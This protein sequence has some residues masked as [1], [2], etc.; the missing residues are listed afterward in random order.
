MYDIVIILIVVA[1]V[2][3][4]FVY[5]ITR[6]SNIIS[7]DQQ[8]LLQSNDDK[9]LTNWY[10]N[11]TKSNSDFE[12]DNREIA[13]RFIKRILDRD[14]DFE[15]I[16]I[17]TN[18]EEQYYKIMKKIPNDDIFIDVRSLIGKS[19]EF[20]IIKNKKL[21][22]KF[23]VEAINLN[24]LNDI[25]LAD[26]DKGAYQHIK[27]LLTVRWG[28]IADLG[29]IGALNDSGSYLYLPTDQEGDEVIVK[30]NIVATKTIRGARINLLCNNWEFETLLKRLK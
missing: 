6:Y 18:L 24:E 23:E 7:D 22:D 9:I 8:L 20:L 17:G 26:Y 13:A 21:R 1:L 3:I 15:H 30:D 5:Y 10:N 12:V 19:W 16:V 2:A 29:D 27:D 25:M 4:I 28:M 11:V 14:V